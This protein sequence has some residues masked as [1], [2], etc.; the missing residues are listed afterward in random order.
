MTERE[1][2]ERQRQREREIERE[3]HRQIVERGE[4]ERYK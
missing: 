1:S 2:G 3:G 4:H